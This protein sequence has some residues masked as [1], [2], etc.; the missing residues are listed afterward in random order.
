MAID[1]NV[2][3]RGRDAA[4]SARL[5][6]H[7]HFH[8]RRGV[9]FCNANGNAN[10]APGGCVCVNAATCDMIYRPVHPP[11]VVDLDVR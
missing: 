9:A 11:I 10:G 4:K 1:L 7:G 5:W 8:D 3:W 2:L 6:V